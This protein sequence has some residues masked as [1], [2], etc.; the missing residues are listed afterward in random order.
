M[1]S[2]D[3]MRQWIT[4]FF[5]P[6]AHTETQAIYQ[7]RDDL[8]LDMPRADFLE[9][10]KR[11]FNDHHDMAGHAKAEYST[12]K[13]EGIL[14]TAVS[15]ILAEYELGFG[16]YFDMIEA[17]ER[18]IMAHACEIEYKNHTITRHHPHGYK[19]ELYGSFPNYYR[20]LTQAL[21]EVAKAATE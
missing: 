2:Y 8:K 19:V 1:T 14:E 13:I 20:T 6:K 16:D 11:A 4:I 18:A 9:M 15:D 12:A 10:A 3:Q 21:N 5:D 7:M 17:F